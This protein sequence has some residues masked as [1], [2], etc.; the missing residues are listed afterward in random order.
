MK[1]AIEKWSKNS[2]DEEGHLAKNKTVGKLIKIEAT[3]EI[4][5][6]VAN[7][8]P[9]LWL[10]HDSVDSSLVTITHAKSKP[11]SFAN[12][13]FFW[14]LTNKEASCSA[15]LQSHEIQ[16]APFSCN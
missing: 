5:K 4:C 3:Y 15:M 10:A 16:H 7:N 12:C 11:A 13:H 9:D 14:L 1:I 6:T 2:K 8:F